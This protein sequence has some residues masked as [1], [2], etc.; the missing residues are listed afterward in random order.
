MAIP[1]AD[2]KRLQ[3]IDRIVEVLKGITAG[4]DYFYTPVD[5]RKG[6]VISPSGYP[7]YVVRSEA[8]GEIEM[9]SDSQ[10]R[11]SFYVAIHGAV[12][13]IGDAVTPLERAL[14]DVRK[15]IEQDFQPAA[16]AGSLITLAT[17]IV[18]DTPPEIDYGPEGQGPLAFFSQ[19]VRITIDG[20]FG[21]I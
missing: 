3:V 7:T 1:S 14:R 9:H 21:E 15:A 12:Q 20:E 13:E 6:F 18:F 8:G 10:W 5:V 19:R 16:G 2:P 17:S 11:E 4:A